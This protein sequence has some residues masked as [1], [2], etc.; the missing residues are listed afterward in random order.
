MTPVPWP[1]LPDEVYKASQGDRAASE[2]LYRAIQPRLRAFLRYQGFDP[3]TSEDIA[4]DISEVVLTK[5][6][7]L[8]NPVTFEAW[9]WTI[10][11][12]HVHAWLRRKQASTLRP[13]PKLPDPIPPDE[14][15]VAAEEH[16]AIREALAQL[17]DRDRTLLWLRE[18]EGLSYREIGNR[19]G[20]ATGAVRVRCHRAR[21]RLEETYENLV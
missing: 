19:L 17:T 14:A 16:Q 11:R 2:T 13:N 10:A 7:T 18:V 21:R 15:V 20:A 12:N 6:G 8:R 9:F 5:I 4:A 1:P 3:T